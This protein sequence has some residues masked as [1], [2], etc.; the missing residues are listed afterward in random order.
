LL[1]FAGL[2]SVV[3]VFAASGFGASGVGSLVQPL[4]IKQRTSPESAK[5][6]REKIDLIT[7][8]I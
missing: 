7:I 1:D 5:G 6:V 8:N 3:V 2:V 4:A